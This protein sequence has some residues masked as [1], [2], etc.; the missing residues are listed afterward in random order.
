MCAIEFDDDNSDAMT[1]L[2]D[3]AKENG[4]QIEN[5]AVKDVAML[6]QDG[7][8]FNLRSAVAAKDITLTDNIIGYL[9]LQLILSESNARASEI[10]ASVI[11]F[12]NNYPNESSKITM[13]PDPFCKCRVSTFKCNP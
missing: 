6:D 9:P 10:G 2:L 7:G 4:A 12:M 1:L 11:K 5:I 13:N 8:E 3:W